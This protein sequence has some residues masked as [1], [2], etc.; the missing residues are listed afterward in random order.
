MGSSNENW[1][2]QNYTNENSGSKYKRV[3][4][5]G[6]WQSWVKMPN[7]V[8]AL[9]SAST[10]DALSANQGKVLSSRFDEIST[11]TGRPKEYT[12]N[13]D[14]INVT[15]FYYVR[16]ASGTFLNGVSKYGYLRTYKSW[17]ENT[18]RKQI[19]MPYD[20]DNIYT[21]TCNNQ[22]TWS[23]WARVFTSG[24]ITTRTYNATISANG[25]S[26]VANIPVGDYVFVKTNNSNCIAFVSESGSNN[27]I[28]VR[29]FASSQQTVTITA[30]SL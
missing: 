9:N 7:V 10:V 26:W 15:S 29:N 25:L 16:N 4:K 3:L 30:K 17:Y 13:I 23:A 28:Y 19:Y 6:A 11:G 22:G 20:T 21:R 24:L 27:Q 14:N 5:N 18:E 1:G 2:L 12:G 8:D